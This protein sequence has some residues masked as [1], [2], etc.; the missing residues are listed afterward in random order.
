MKVKTMKQ[1]F[2]AAITGALATTGPVHAQRN[3]DD[4]EITTTK[5][6]DTIF[7]LEGAGGNMGLAIGEDGAFLIDDQFAP[8]SDKI[9]AAIAEV[10]NAPVSFL[11]NT[12]YHGD[13][14]GGN[15][16]FS[17]D[18]TLIVAHDNVRTRLE[19]NDS[20]PE[21]GLPVITFSET[22]TF[23]W[24]DD[25]IFV[26]HP[27]N[28]HTDGDGIVFFHK[29]NVMHTGDV[30]FSGRYPYIDVDSGGSLN[31]ALAALEAIAAQVNDDTKIIP[32]HGPVSAKQ[33]VLASIELLKTVRERVQPL[34]DEGQSLEDAV[35]S[36]PLA[37]LNATFA[38]A[39]IDGDRMTEIAYRSLSTE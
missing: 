16:A 2:F 5:V 38:W 4:V 19:K 10:T 11:L 23:H 25:E 32:G 21:A 3:Y 22:A 13:H 24:N 14:S 31:G 6:A 17:E 18:G 9:K 37:D 15:A 20:F 7:M 33:D 26:L 35:A 28:A 39:F 29:A 8:L 36:D 34:I 30:F 1:F 12:H 27:E